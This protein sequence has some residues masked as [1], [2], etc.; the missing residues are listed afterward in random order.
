MNER[1]EI[2]EREK[3]YE[4]VWKQPV[5]VVANRYGVSN[6]ALAKACRKLAVPFP[7]RGYWARIRAGRKPPP[8]PP[9]P[10][11]ESSVGNQTTRRVSGRDGATA[12]KVTNEKDDHSP[13]NSTKVPETSD[14]P[15]PTEKKTPDKN[16]TAR[17]TSPKEFPEYLYCTINGW[18]RTFR[19]GVNRFRSIKGRRE[20]EAYEEWD[21]LQVFATIR[22]HDKAVRGRKR[23]GQRVELWVFPTHVPRAD[24]REDPEAVGGVWTEQGKLFGSLHVPADAFYSLFPCLATNH[25]K[26]LELRILRMHYRHGDIA[27]IRFA[28]E[29]TPMEDLLQ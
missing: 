7:P 16:P 19:F 14:I 23:T 6:V 9:L 22:H 13:T 8:R 18:Q 26:E 25:F 1:T 29:E 28:P 4:E 5:P 11:Y 20:E 24:W 12:S 27:G 2:H 21:H 10:P 3:L 15:C 17:K